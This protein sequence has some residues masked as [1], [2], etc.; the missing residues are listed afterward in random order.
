[1]YEKQPFHENFLFHNIMSGY[2]TSS[3]KKQVLNLYTIKI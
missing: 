1:M 2:S 3:L